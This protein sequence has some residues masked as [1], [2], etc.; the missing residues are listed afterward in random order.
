MRSVLLASTVSALAMSPAFASAKTDPKP[1]D[2]APTPATTDD[3]TKARIAP[4]IVGEPTKDVPMPTVTSKRGS[5]SVYPFDSLTEVGMSFAVANKTAA[6]MTAIVSAVNRKHQVVKTN[7]DGTP[8]KRTIKGVL[9]DKNE[10]VSIKHFK[11]FDV[12]DESGIMARV[13]RDK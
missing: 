4:V 1:A 2:P 12:T 11:A 7:S 3:T 8:A 9:T 10:M 6:D 5:K 13:F